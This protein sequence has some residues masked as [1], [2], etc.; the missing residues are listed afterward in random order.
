MSTFL[1]SLHFHLDP[2]PPTHI[3]THTHLNNETLEETPPARFLCSLRSEVFSP[4]SQG[5]EIIKTLLVPVAEPPNTR[6]VTLSSAHLSICVMTSKVVKAFQAGKYGASLTG[7]GGLF[8]LWFAAAPRLVVS[9]GGCCERSCDRMSVL[10][11]P[12]LL[13]VHELH[14]WQVSDDK[15]TGARN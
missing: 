4:Q 14:W 2:P 7:R 8:V 9:A 12:P 11:P 6:S 5:V 13:L 10:C 15:G 1:S 3:H